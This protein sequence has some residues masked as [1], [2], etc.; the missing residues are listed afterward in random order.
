MRRGLPGLSFLFLSTALAFPA[1]AQ[2]GEAPP[3]GGAQASR[4]TP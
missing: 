3:A 4:T 1:L 2:Q